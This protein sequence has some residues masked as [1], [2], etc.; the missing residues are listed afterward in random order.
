MRSKGQKT[1]YITRDIERALAL[2]QNDDYIIISNKTGEILDTAELLKLDG[3]KKSIDANGASVLVFKNNPLIESICKSNHWKLLNPPSSL[4]EKIENKITQVEWLGEYA[5]KYLPP[6]QVATTKDL[7]WIGRPSVLQWAHGHTGQGTIVINSENEL[8]SFQNKFP[9]RSARMTEFVQGPSFTVNVVV[10]KN[11]ILVG[12]TSY[13]IT[14]LAPF[15]DNP[16]STI[17]NDWSIT[18]TLLTEEETGYISSIATSIGERMRQDGWKGLFGIDVIKDESLN[19]VFLLEINARQPAST[20]C[21]S[22]L[23]RKTVAQQ[24]DIPEIGSRYTTFE[25]HLSALYNKEVQGELIEINDGAQIIQRITKK[26]KTVPGKVIN[27][28]NKAGYETVSYQ[29]N[30]PNSDLLRIRST[31]GIIESHGKLNARGKEISKT[32]HN[33]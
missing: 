6:H 31:K 33:S 8:V 30:E 5:E 23:Q 3:T 15:T 13:Q 2:D 9:D 11:K 24:G 22:S 17:G 12:N 16:L 26:I 14:G 29:N 7:K 25:A 28:L 21:E 10:A 32:I 18:H 20:T 1:A 19:K 4:S 27:S